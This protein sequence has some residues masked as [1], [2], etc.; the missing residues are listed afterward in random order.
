MALAF[1]QMGLAPEVFWSMSPD[2]F[3]AAVRG[4]E[5]QQRREEWRLGHIAA[6][7][8]EVN[9]DTKRRPEPYTASDVF[10]HLAP[11]SREAPQIN[12]DDCGMTDE[13]LDRELKHMKGQQ[14]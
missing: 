7:Y 6:L 11:A 9:R 8:L 14:D 2:E 5:E 1:G 4:W 13:E 12:D 10:P 3:D